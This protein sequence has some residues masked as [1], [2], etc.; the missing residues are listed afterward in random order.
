MAGKL[1]P[2]APV[3]SPIP[4]PFKQTPPALHWEQLVHRSRQTTAVALCPLVRLCRPYPVAAVRIWSSDNSDWG[5]AAAGYTTGISVW[6]HEYADNNNYNAFL[7][8]IV[9]ASNVSAVTDPGGRPVLVYCDKTVEGAGAQY[10]TL[11]KVHSYAYG[12]WFFAVAELQ[13]LYAPSYGGKAMNSPYT[14]D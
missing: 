7:S 1:M 4:K 5:T 6:L 12:D 9:C 14:Y 10:V 3:S 8:G 11:Q 13:V 2:W